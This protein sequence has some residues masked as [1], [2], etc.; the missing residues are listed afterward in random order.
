MKI[1]VKKCIKCASTA[2]VKN[3]FVNGWQRYKCKNCGYQYTKQSPRRQSVSNLILASSLYSFGVS[4][5]EI[6]RL[7][8]VTPMTVVRWIKKYHIYYMTAIA[9][10]EKRKKMS[11]SEVQE[12][13]SEYPKSN[14]MS[15]CRQLPSGTKIDVF[16]H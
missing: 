6:A 3:G 12:I 13:I 15:I 11:L 5:R 14:I 1:E 2:S 10:L 7:L 16:I 9:P 4:K 8:G